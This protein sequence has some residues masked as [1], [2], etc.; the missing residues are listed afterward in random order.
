MDSHGSSDLISQNHPLL[1]AR[2]VASNTRCWRDQLPTDQA[3]G[4]LA[5]ISLAAIMHGY[6]I[7]GNKNGA[8]LLPDVFKLFHFDLWL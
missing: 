3:A 4:C 7:T 2:A 1:L 6:D 8:I 5:A